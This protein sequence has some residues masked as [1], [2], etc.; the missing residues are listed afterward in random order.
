[1]IFAYA[2][3]PSKSYAISSNNMNWDILILTNAFGINLRW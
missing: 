3:V 1:M 2:I